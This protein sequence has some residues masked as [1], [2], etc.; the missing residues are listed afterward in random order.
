LDPS[1]LLARSLTARLT[2]SRHFEDSL[3][4]QIADPT[5]RRLALIHRHADRWS[6]TS[7]A[8]Y[9]QTSRPKV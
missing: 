1:N 5:Q 9:L 7:I 4:D 8:G 6:I 2:A 3:H